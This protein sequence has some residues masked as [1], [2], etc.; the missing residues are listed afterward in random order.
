MAPSSRL[1]ITLL[2][3]TFAAV[4]VEQAAACTVITVGKDATAD[5]S[6]ITTHTVDSHRTSSAVEVV[7]PRKHPPGTMIQLTTR[8]EDND[9][10]MERYSR[11]PTGEIPQVPKTYGYLAPAYAPMNEHQVA[12]GESTFGGREELRSKEGLID[13]ETTQRLM[14]ERATTAREAIRIGGALIEEHGWSTR[15]KP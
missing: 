11:V 14:L 8:G 15:G 1:F 13:C 5:G 9:S 6:V 7:P 2:A 12:I 4:G 3:V 10:R